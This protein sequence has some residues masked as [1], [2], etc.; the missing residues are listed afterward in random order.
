MATLHAQLRSGECGARWQPPETAELVEDHEYRL[1]LRDPVAGIVWSVGSSRFPFALDPGHDEI[2][3]ADLEMSARDAFD[4]AWKAP[5]EGDLQARR[6]TEDPTWSPV[7]EHGRVELVGG[8]A[9]RVVRRTAYQP[10]N[11]V[12]VGHLIVPTATGHLDFWAVARATVTGLRESVVMMT[13]T[14]LGND[15]DAADPD[16]E[17]ARA[18][19]GEDQRIGRRFPKQAVYDDPGLD[20]RFPDHPLAVVRRAIGKLCESVTITRAAPRVADEIQLEEPRCAFAAPTRFVPIPAAVLKLHPTLRLLVRSGVEN[21]TRNLEVW[22]LEH[23]QFRRRD[24]RAELC[25]LAR[26]TVAGWAGEGAT[27]ITAEVEAIDDF[28]GRPQAQQAVSMRA[29]GSPVRTVFRWWVE[30][31][32]IVFRLGSSGPP[33][34]SDTEHIALV[35]AGQRTWRRLDV[36]S[37]PRRP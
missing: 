26:D 8:T 2:L 3:R 12:V 9:L 7:V 20:A 11:E 34:I 30:P 1:I 13:M 31:D 18:E 29:E 17:V 16:A 27:D 10:G 28:D 14:D 36:V 33:G 15:L 23:V 21:W 24:P 37:A 22:R 6:R 19:R 32:G 4:K 25:E 5:A 35:D